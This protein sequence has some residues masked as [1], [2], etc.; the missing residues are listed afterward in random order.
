MYSYRHLMG[1]FVS[2]DIRG[3]FAGS[4][5]GIL[6][7]LITP[8]SN[9]IIYYFIFSI[10]IRIQVSA[11]ENGTDSFF[12]YFLSGFF[13]WLIL[14]E[15]LSRSTGVLLENSNLITKVVF[16]VELLPICSMFTSLIINGIGFIAFLLFLAISGFFHPMWFV[17]I[18]LMGI[19]LIF[20]IGLCCLL[21][22]LCV[23]FRDIQEFM[24]LILTLWFY[25]TPIIYP[26]SMLPESYRFIVE[27]NPAN[28]YIQLVREILLTHSFS[29]EILWQAIFFSVISY[30]LGTCFFMKSAKAFG[31]VL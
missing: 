28:T 11:G 13:P 14:S 15:S 3:R 21:S 29:P 31:D 19:Y 12:I 27:W 2:K 18:P 8:L 26:F 7:A 5:A 20:I 30:C 22:A 6:W 9:I 10:V 1:E 23:F 16:P 17:L 24:N 4:M 25:A